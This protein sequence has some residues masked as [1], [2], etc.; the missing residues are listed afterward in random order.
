MKKRF[1]CAAAFLLIFCLG[2]CSG[3]R[4]A[5]KETAEAQED[6]KTALDISGRNAYN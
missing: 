2:G 1:L 3:G 5:G 6:W 4:E